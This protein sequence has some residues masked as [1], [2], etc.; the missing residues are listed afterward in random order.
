[1]SPLAA[2]LLGLAVAATIV[3][4]C[5]LYFVWCLLTGRTK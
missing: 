1:M 2:F 5:Y 3:L 4:G